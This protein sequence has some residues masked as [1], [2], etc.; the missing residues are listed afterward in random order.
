MRSPTMKRFLATAALLVFVLYAS[1]YVSVKYQIPGKRQ[2]RDIVEV[3]R[4][5]TIRLKGNKVEYTR[6][7]SAQEECVESLFPH[8]GEAPCWYLRRYPQEHV[9]VDSGPP[10]PWIDLP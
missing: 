5:F 3:Q 10:R 4:D 9:D 2:V 8:F 7:R 6:A 1:D